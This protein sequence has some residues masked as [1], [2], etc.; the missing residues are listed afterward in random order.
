MMPDAANSRS[1]KPLPRQKNRPS[2]SDPIW[3]RAAGRNI[4]AHQLICATVLGA[5]YAAL[6]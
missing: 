6:S 2:A 5:I 3:S 1:P 4:T